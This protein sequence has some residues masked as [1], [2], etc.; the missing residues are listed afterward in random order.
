L[1]GGTRDVL[2]KLALRIY[3]DPTADA[4]KKQ[5]AKGLLYFIEGKVPK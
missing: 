2:R 5:L 3:R 4:E 1:S